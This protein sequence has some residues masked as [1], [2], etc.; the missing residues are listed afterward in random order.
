MKI[1][2][3]PV[4]RTLRPSTGFRAPAH[5]QDYG[6][7]QDFENWLLS[8]EYL[9]DSPGEADFQYLPIYWNRYYCN[10]W[11]SQQSVEVLQT[12]ILR[13]VSTNI[14][15][16]TICEYD[17]V[18]MQ[19]SLDLCNMTIFTASRHSD[20]GCIDIPLLCSAHTELPYKEDRKYLASFMGKFETHGLREE[21]RQSLGGR[22]DIYLSESVDTQAYVELMADSYIVL[23][24]R[25]YGGQSFRFYEAMQFGCVPMLIGD[26]DT[27]PF[28]RWIDWKKSSFFTSLMPILTL[29]TLAD[30][31]ETM[32]IM[33]QNAK[34][35]WQ[36]ELHYGKWCK[37]VIKELEI[38]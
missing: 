31:Y 1:Y 26:V 16:F 10:H 18:S 32:K 8:S 25:G 30:N 27:R 24:P 20:N 36:N 38:L 14:P 4:D 37:Y 33:G 21:M 13:L 29:N 23:A 5:N 12:E 15:T 22:E 3:L 34:Q 6:V 9:T 11:G 35:L 2:K 19:P 7:E 28:K 17:V